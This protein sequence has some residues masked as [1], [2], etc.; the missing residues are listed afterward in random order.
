MATTT[1]EKAMTIEEVTRS[2]QNTLEYKI[3]P[4]LKRA[5][6]ACLKA[7]ENY[8]EAAKKLNEAARSAQAKR[9]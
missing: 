9:R 2:L 8:A 4:N 5:E 3:L 1:K 7:A 6:V